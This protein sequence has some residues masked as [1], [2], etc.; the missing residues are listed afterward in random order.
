V[1]V[2]DVGVIIA[3]GGSGS[4]TGSSELKQFR[5]VAGKPMLLHS[6]QRFQERADVAMVVCVLP[7]GYMADPPPW[8]FQCDTDRLLLCPGGKERAESVANGLEDIPR[9]C[10][11]I[12]VHDAARPFFTNRMAGDVIQAAR[13]DAC[14]V[15]VI[16]MSDT[17]KKLADDLSVI[18]TVDR[19]N[20][21]RVQ[22]PQ[23]FPRDILFRAHSLPLEERLK[24]PDDAAI[25][26]GLGY[27]CVGVPGSERAIKITTE[28]DFAVAEALSNLPE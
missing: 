20:L 16:R 22:T 6:L 3:A 24:Y 17:V 8:I 12:V 9:E 13:T 2:R 18:E 11:I 5:W 4:R 23:A 25:C 21:W 28:S 10:S 7:R 27:K 15:P 26:E 19:R 14:A 1:T